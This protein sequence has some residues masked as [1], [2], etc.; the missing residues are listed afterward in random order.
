VF[1][2]LIRAEISRWKSIVK[3]SGPRAV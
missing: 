2:A 1:A 3:E